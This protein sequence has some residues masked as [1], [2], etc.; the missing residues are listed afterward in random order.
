M[1]ISTRL[2][3]NVVDFTQPLLYISYI[4]IYYS[5]FCLH[6]GSSNAAHN[7]HC[8]RTEPAFYCIPDTVTRCLVD[9]V[10][11]ATKRRLSGDTVSIVKN[12]SKRSSPRSMQRN[13]SNGKRC[14]QSTQVKV[15]AVAMLATGQD[16]QNQRTRLRSR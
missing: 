10:W 6:V 14:G 2:S 7:S 15:T 13:C 3:E 11:N 9:C 12:A 16:D 5:L 1:C 4:C 8:I